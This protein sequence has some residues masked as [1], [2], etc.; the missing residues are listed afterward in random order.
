MPV[1]SAGRTGDRSGTGDLVVRVLPDI[2]A[3]HKTFDYTVPAKWA[4]QVRPGARVR[5][6]LHGRPVGAWVTETGVEPPDGVELH[7]LSGYSGLGPPPAMVA[8]A[9]WAAWRWA[10]PT[11][12]FLGTASPRRNVARLPVPPMW[13]APAERARPAERAGLLGA[14]GFVDALGSALARTEGPSLLRV[15]PAEDLLPLVEA[16]INRRARGVLVLVPSAGW[17]DRLAA[18]LRLRGV[19]VAADWAQAAAGWPVVVGSRAAAFSPLEVLSAV[20][21]LDAHDEAYQEQRAPT[22]NAWEVVAERAHRDGAPCVLVSPCPSAVQVQRCVEWTPERSIERGGWPAL[23]VVDLRVSDPRTGLLT[24]ELTRFARN[25]LGGDRPFVCVL[26]RTG[27]AKL[28]ACAACGE[29]ARCERCGRPLSQIAE[30][31]VCPGCGE[32]RPLVCAACGRT[33]LKVLRPG[34]SRLRDE[35]E[36]LLGVSVG[37]VAGAR[38]RGTDERVRDEPVLIGTE[39]VLHRVRAAAAVAFLDF[40]QQLLAPRFTAGEEALSLLARAGRLTGRRAPEVGARARVL[41]QTR[42]PDH[43]VLDAARLGDPGRLSAHELTLRR[44]LALPPFS[45]LALATGPAADDLSAALGTLPGITAAALGDERWMIRAVDH[46][47]LCDAL[48]A[49]PRPA[50]RLR[51]AVDPTEV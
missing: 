25:A 16:V 4:D 1:G 44:E 15:P 51:V 13:A 45:A 33:K 40:D 5:I 27:R 31:L 11:S 35:L 3:V 46:Q 20:V 30:R 17:A 6:R 34:V 48:A 8:L 38:T 9:R 19:P 10:G 36:T 37:E 47:V 50:G 41:V 24:E 26:N 2:A 29:L 32:E 18:R 12:S 49:T 42:L 39:A 22:F 23:S 28:L 21:V 43:E 7:A 14:G